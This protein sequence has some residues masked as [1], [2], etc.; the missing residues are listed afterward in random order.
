MPTGRRNGNVG[1][2]KMH[3]G[4]AF[5]S[6]FFASSV[7]L[8][9]P[10]SFRTNYR[11]RDPKKWPMKAFFDMLRD[12]TQSSLDKKEI[13][14]DSKQKIKVKVWMIPISAG[15]YIF[16]EADCCCFGDPSQFTLVSPSSIHRSHSPPLPPVPD[17]VL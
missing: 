7:G 15:Y 5:Y 11:P 3:A 4:V 10:P 8:P 6:V 13:K 16:P 2:C 17:L 1:T 12:Q 9:F 14:L